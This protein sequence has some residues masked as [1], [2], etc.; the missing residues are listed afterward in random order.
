[1]IFPVISKFDAEL[2]KNVKV[3]MLGTMSNMSFLNTPRQV[4]PRRK[5]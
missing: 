1:M 4:T 2:L 3:A 5:V